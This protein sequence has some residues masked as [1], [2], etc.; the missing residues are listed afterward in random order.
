MIAFLV[1][2]GRAGGALLEVQPP[3]APGAAPPPWVLTG[4]ARLSLAPHPDA[5]TVLS[6]EL[7]PDTLTLAAAA[8]DPAALHYF[9]LADGTV[10]PLPPA[11]PPFTCQAGDAYIAVTPAT[12]RLAAAEPGGAGAAVA[13]FLH[14]RDYFNAQRLAQALL[15]HLYELTPGGPAQER[16]G[17]GVV[18]IE[19]R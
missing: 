15:D 4:P 11:P 16:D 2:F 5:P 19:A 10:K 17:V 9:R 7:D 6:V 18:V 8:L 3:A 12:A 1:G 13:R 14:L